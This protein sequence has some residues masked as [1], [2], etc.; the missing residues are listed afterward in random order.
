[1]VNSPLFE[2]VTLDDPDDVRTRATAYADA[3]S[4]VRAAVEHT[5]NTWRPIEHQYNADESA[6]VVFAMDRPVQQAEQLESV[7][8]D[9]RSALAGYADA[10]Q[11]LAYRR[12]TLLTD[13]DQFWAHGPGIDDLDAREQAIQRLQVR[14]YALAQDKDDAQNRC[15][16]A[17]RN[18]STT[19]AP[20]NS[21][22]ES[23]RTASEAS[24]VHN[25]DPGAL[26]ETAR[27]AGF[28]PGDTYDDGLDTLPWA[29]QRLGDAFGA[30]SNYFTH[31]LAEGLVE[32]K[33]LRVDWVPKDLAQLASTNRLVGRFTEKVLDWT[34]NHGLAPG[35]V[36]DIDDSR[37]P[38]RKATGIADGAKKFLQR[39][40]AFLNPEN[41]IPKEGLGASRDLWR[42]VGKWA[43]RAGGA[44]GAG[45]TAVASWQEDSQKHPE[46]SDGEKV[47]R[48]STKTAGSVGGG[49]AGAKAGAVLGATI[50]TF[51]GPGPGTAVGAVIGGIIGGIAGS[52][53]GSEVA[54][55]I[56]TGVHN[57][58][59]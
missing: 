54:D 30:G 7:I 38:F 17:L 13:I 9:A 48:A 23:T 53:T 22:P 8:D 19:V 28:I 34:P 39:S 18:L 55:R 4:T 26:V 45:F 5:R 15:A 49:L 58:T 43:G 21:R 56:N 29:A 3:A 35:T 1:M 47:L 33:G 11:N 24:D 16:R 42:N 27:H 14:C 31:N 50:G 46:M 57:A 12:S 41:L 59:H 25:P 6:Q 40:V 10:L 32:Q 51:F 20:A 36:L 37:H 52:M 2:V 44:V